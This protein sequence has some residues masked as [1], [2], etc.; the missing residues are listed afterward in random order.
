M[1]ATVTDEQFAARELVRDWAAG[2]PARR[3]AV[4][5][6]EQGE[7]TPGGRYSTAWPIWVC[8]VSR[9][10]RTRGGAGGSIEDLCAMVEEAAKALVPGPVA[11]TALAT[12]VVVR[13]AAAG[14]TGIGRTLR[15][16][17]RSTATSS[18]TSATSQASGTAAVGAGRRRRRRAAGAGRAGSGC[19]STPPATACRRAAA[20]HRLLPA[21]GAG[22]ADLGAGHGAGRARTGWRTWP[23][24]CWR[25]KRRAS[26]VGRWTP[27]SPTPRCASS[28]ASRSAASRP[29][30]HLCAEMLC[31]AEQAEV[32][33]AD[34][35]A[36]RRRRRRPPVVHRR[37]PRREHRHRRGEGQR[38]G[39]HPG[40]RRH[41][42][43]LGARRAPVPAPGP[44]HRPVPRRRRA[45]AAPDRRADPGRRPPSARHRPQR[46]RR[47]APRDRRGGRRGRRAARGQAAGG[48]GRSGAAGAALAGAVRARRR[49]RPS[50]C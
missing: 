12:L 2:A 43:H 10:P 8:S 35:A 14:G 30:K 32:A 39:L 15:R 34:A 36:R 23:R 49:R 18:S 44:R 40:A 31:R 28:S 1:A 48:A 46:G 6:I 9:S 19:W 20:G 38:Q 37:G 47:P 22:G 11:T 33:A 16:A 25:P 17:W 3:H 24:R 50:S 13:S 29:I 41:R 21:V 5:D 27:P 42:L 7:P 45:L 26:P 4:R